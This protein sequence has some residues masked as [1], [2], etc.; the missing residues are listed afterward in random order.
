MAPPPAAGVARGQTAAAA[1]AA[2]EQYR[3]ISASASSPV[4]TSGGMLP[5]V[6]TT[7]AAG[8]R[9]GPK[10]C[11]RHSSRN[12]N[13]DFKRRKRARPQPLGERQSQ[14]AAETT[15]NTTAKSMCVSVQV[16]GFGS[17]VVGSTPGRISMIA[18]ATLV[19]R[20]RR[21]MAALDE[22]REEIHA[23]FIENVLTKCAR[24]M[25]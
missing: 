21:D 11:A 7:A 12:P 15:P 4:V 1:A 25:K 24:K 2:G 5:P 6:S 22:V 14:T 13:E 18:G 19:A 9:L 20:L 3:E 10:D 17:G 23:L 16:V 8:K